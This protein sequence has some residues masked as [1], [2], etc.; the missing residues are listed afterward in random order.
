[1]L[2]IALPADRGWDDGA[3]RWPEVTLGQTLVIA[4]GSPDS[5]ITWPRADVL[6]EL[7]LN[8]RKADEEGGLRALRGMHWHAWDTSTLVGTKASVAITLRRAPG[9][10]AS[11]RLSRA[12][13]LCLEAFV[14]E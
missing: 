8:G 2:S 1:M 3:L 13:E 11:E 4:G 10:A 7:S 9:P 5:Q 14:L 6:L 12:R